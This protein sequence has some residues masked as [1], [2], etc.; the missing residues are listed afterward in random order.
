ML[1]QTLQISDLE[2]YTVIDNP[3]IIEEIKILWGANYFS[4]DQIVSFRINLK[5]YDEV[6]SNKIPN[7]FEKLKAKIPTLYDHHCS[8]GKKGGFFER[9]QEGTL[10]GHV[11]EHVAIELQMLA[12]MNVGF[13]KTR[14]TKVKGAYNVVFRFFDEIAGIYA[15]KASLNLIN[16]LL[17]NLDF[18]VNEI[19]Q[20][21]IFIRENRLLG[22]STQA[23]VDE[24]VRREIP[25]IRLDKYNRVQLG[26]GKYRKIIRATM[27]ETTSLLAVETTDDKFLTTQILEDAGIPVPKTIITENLEDVINFHSLINKPIIIKPAHGYQGKRVSLDLN[28]LESIT[29][30]F[31]FAKEFDDEIIAQ[32][33]ILGGTFRLLII[34][35]KFVA[36]VRLIPAYIIGNETST[37]AQLIDKL[38]NEDSR[39]FGDKG[40][41]TKVE[42]DEDTLKIIELKNYTLETILPKDEIIYLKNSGNMRLGASSIDVTDTIH[43]TNIEIAERAAKLLN[44]NVAGVDILSQNIKLNMLENNGKIIEI[45]AAPDFRMHIKPTMG[46][47]RYVQRNYIS[48][49]YPK[50]QPTQIPIISI[51]GSLG[52]NFILELIYKALKT[53]N[54]SVGLQSKKGL[55]VNQNCIINS[56]ATHKIENVKLLLKEPTIDVAILETTV[57][58]ILNSGL[59]YDFSHFG[60]VLNI[61]NKKEDYFAYDHI[62][63]I[64]DVAYAKSV[65]AEQVLKSGFAILNADNEMILE[66]KS[67]VYSNCILFSTVSHNK[68][69]RKHIKNNLPAV[70]IENNNIVY[71][72]QNLPITIVNINELLKKSEIKQNYIKECLLATVAVLYNMDFQVEEIR[73]ILL[74]N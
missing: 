38:N 19:V 13:G 10:L 58:S 73:K 29:N 15:G 51:T 67:R 33:D 23:I 74:S 12:G 20:N 21:L 4:G 66:M 3:I 54:Y 1:I 47:P 59:G 39:E 24:A 62:R 52:K 8:L 60:I 2:K 22:P 69:V 32:E 57:E 16:S 70:I 53:K 31:N 42:I 14:E 18:D 45:N 35:F 40:I 48:M 41:L 17:L 64:V 63:T 5:E 46:T 36:G 34:D 11:M 43:S 49:I 26:T 6:F 44:L 61:E 7:F 27:P 55:F 56:D 50:N 65:V 9:M 71:Y 30:A 37:I 72:D 68:D 25:V 28:N